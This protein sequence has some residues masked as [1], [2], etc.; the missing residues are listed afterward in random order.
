MGERE[1]GETV[2]GMTVK[3]GG[4]C[5]L[6]MWVSF[7]YMN[8]SIETHRMFREVPQYSMVFQHIPW[9]SMI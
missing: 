2:R 4:H 9:G 6:D 8:L 3:G 5:S 1:M 7:I